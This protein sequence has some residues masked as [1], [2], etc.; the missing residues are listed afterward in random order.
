MIFRFTPKIDG[1]DF[2]HLIWEKYM[3]VYPHTFDGDYSDF[4]KKNVLGA[5]HVNTNSLGS[6]IEYID[7]ASEQYYTMF[8]L[9]W[10]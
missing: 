2:D 8:L 5:L 4:I 7:F 6:I 1:A 3:E 10:T 9:R